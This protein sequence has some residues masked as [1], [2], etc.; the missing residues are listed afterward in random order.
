MQ[1]QNKPTRT[2]VDAFLGVN[3]GSGQHSYSE[4]ELAYFKELI[5]SQRASRLVDLER[6]RSQLTDA[7]E[8]AGE[9]GAYHSH[10]A[11]NGTS[12]TD[13]ERL[14][15]MIARQQ[16]QINMLDRALE[17]IANK[18][19]GICKVTGKRIAKE[20]LEALP[21]TEVCISTKKRRSRY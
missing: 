19:Y 13:Q 2:T 4:T 16:K 20:R 1:V 5:L 3:E 17:R 14:Y 21:H 11:D 12:A 18:S 10:L 8:N 6:M 15:L 7:I 9:A